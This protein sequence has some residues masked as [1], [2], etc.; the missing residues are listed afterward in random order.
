[1]EKHGSPCPTVQLP[2]GLT[3][4]FEVEPPADVG[5]QQFLPGHPPTYVQEDRPSTSTGHGLPPSSATP[6][7]PPVNPC[8][9]TSDVIHG[10]CLQLRRHLYEASNLGNMSEKCA[11]FEKYGFLMKYDLVVVAKTCPLIVEH[12]ETMVILTSPLRVVT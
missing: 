3:Q 7:S 8:N 5:S 4:Y 2:T 9:C 10:S 1:M 6:Q 11:C 12:L